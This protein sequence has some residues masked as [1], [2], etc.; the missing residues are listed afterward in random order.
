MIKSTIKAK[1][2]LKITQGDTALFQH[3]LNVG[4]SIAQ[5]GSYSVVQGL[6]EMSIED[7]ETFKNK[8]GEKTGKTTNKNK[9]YSV[10]NY[11]ATYK[12]LT[13]LQEKLTTTINDFKTLI[14]NDL[15]EHWHTEQGEVE[16]DRF[17]EAVSN[18]LAVKKA[19]AQVMRD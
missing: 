5:S 1:A 3:A 9:M 16:I 12:T 10:Y 19:Q 6:N 11:L 15:D 2:T 7:L 8:M 18:I 17:K 4:S 14:A 13:S